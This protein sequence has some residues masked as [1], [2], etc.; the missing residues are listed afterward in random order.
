MAIPEELTNLAIPEL[1]NK[2]KEN[3][4][5]PGPIT[6]ATKHLYVK[7]LARLHTGITYCKV[8][9]TSLANYLSTGSFVLCFVF[10]FGG[11]GGGRGQGEAIFGR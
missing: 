1:R 7:R 8:I 4:E 6:P 3:G 9:L 5:V 10:F 11:G 2:L